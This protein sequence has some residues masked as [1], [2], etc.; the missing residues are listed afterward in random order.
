[1]RAA[2]LI[3]VVCPTSAACSS[4][5]NASGSTNY[6]MNVD[7]GAEFYGTKGQMF[8]SRRGKVAVLNESNKRV[9]LKI[10]VG[11][12][13]EN[14]HVANFIAAIRTGVPLNAEIE[15]G[16]LGASLCHLGNIATRSAVVPFRPP[17]RTHGGRRPGRS[18]PCTRVPPPLGGAGLV[19]VAVV[20]SEP[21]G[22][23]R[24]DKP[25]GS[26]RSRTYGQKSYHR[27]RPIWCSNWL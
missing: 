19:R 7:S 26:P 13:D 18:P 11:G 6:P 4:T 10:P 25:A 14:A 12:Q 2:G 21:P 1:M 24:R 17:G 9:D 27:P 3:P 5:N 8:L 15:I 22:L 20:C 16:H 23:S